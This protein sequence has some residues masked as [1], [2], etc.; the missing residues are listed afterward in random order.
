MPKKSLMI[1]IFILILTACIA[2]CLEIP[3][4]NNHTPNGTGIYVGPNSTDDFQNI[5]DAI[6]AAENNSIIYVREGNYYYYET[7]S[8]NKSIHLISLKEGGASLIGYNQSASSLTVIQLDADNCTIDGF[9]I[10]RNGLTITTGIK[11]NSI[12][13]IIINN[14]ITN[15]TDGITLEKSK[16]QNTIISNNFTSNLYGMQGERSADNTIA[17]NIFSSNTLYGIYF[18]YQSS[19]NIIN[20]NTFY[21]NNYALRI[22]GSSDNTIF[23]NCFVNNTWGLYFCCGATDNTAY[24]NAFYTNSNANIHED[25]TLTNSFN[26]TGA[27]GNYYDTYNGTDSNHDGFG[28]TP[29]SV[30]GSTHLDHQ[31]LIN[32]PNLLF[33][34]DIIDTLS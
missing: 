17:N 24:N 12:N 30:E 5:Q 16:G 31:P 22:K 10:T 21:K 9:V 2:G 26:L 3:S 7:L 33:C 15:I 32:P 34:K 11:I 8:I 6:N 4:N 27:G 28:D 19:R 14:T 1:T 23:N 13:N 20:N 29:Y 18:S 25:Q